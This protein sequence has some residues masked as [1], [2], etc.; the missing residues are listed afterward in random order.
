VILEIENLHWID[1]TSAEWLTAFVEHLGGI[2]VLLVLTYR[3]GYRPPWIEKSYATQLALPYLAAADSRRM[4]HALLQE[5]LPGATVLEQ[6]VAKAGGNPL[7]LEEL[8]RG[9]QEQ[10]EGAGSLDLPATINVVLNARLQRLTGEARPAACRGDRGDRSA[11]DVSRGGGGR[12]GRP[13][14]R[15]GDLAG[16]GIPPCDPL[17][18]RAGLQV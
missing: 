18:S 2:P 3:P 12:S 9:V 5:R 14:A 10:S 15:V 13:A 11:A 8:A 17:R 16:G 6:L 4:L 1:A 7:F